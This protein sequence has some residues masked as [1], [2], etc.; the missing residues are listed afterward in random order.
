MGKQSGFLKKMQD[1]RIGFLL[2]GERIGR[3]EVV[4]AVAI[5]LHESGWGY[6]RIRAL[7]DRT[8]ALLDYYAP[9]FSVGME[10]DVYQERMDNEL[11]AIVKNESEF[12][13]FNVRYDEIKTAGYDR[14]VKVDSVIGCDGVKK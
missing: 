11:R 1:N 13:P 5:A 2:T 10:Q 4:D 14:A 12:V 3:Q 9:A 6:G 8:S 7:L